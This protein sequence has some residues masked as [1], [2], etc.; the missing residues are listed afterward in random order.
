MKKLLGIVVLGLLVFNNSFSDEKKYSLF[1]V[2]LGDDV[3]KYNP[4]EGIIESRIIIDPPNPNDNF[5]LYWASINKKTNKIGIIGAIHKKNY[6]FG[7]EN[8]EREALLEKIL[9]IAKKCKVDNEVFSEVI[10]KGSQFK[11]FNNTLEDFK[12]SLSSTSL[13]IFDGDKINYGEDGNIKFSINTQCINRFGTLVKG[14]EPGLRADI[15]LVDHRTLY[16]TVKDNEDFEKEQL[17]KSGLQ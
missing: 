1:G 10:S 9:S 7:N 4:V 16:Q 12:S 8:I 2:V 11:D 15:S 17:D 6:P 14:E 5:I 3:N 13:Y